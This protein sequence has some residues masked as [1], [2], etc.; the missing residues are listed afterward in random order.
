MTEEQL[1]RER[2]RFVIDLNKIAP[3]K[4]KFID[5]MTRDFDRVTA[6]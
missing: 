4:H 2:S 6:L 1:A 5:K 3:N